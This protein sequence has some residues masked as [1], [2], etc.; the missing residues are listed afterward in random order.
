LPG[1]VSSQI[2][3][4]YDDILQVE[5]TLFR[6]PRFVFQDS[7]VFQDM[8]SVPQGEGTSI[9]GSDD[10]H[11][12]VLSSYLAHDFEQLMKVLLPQCVHGSLQPWSR[13]DQT[14]DRI[15]PRSLTCRRRTGCLSSSLRLSGISN[16]FD[17]PR[18]RSWTDTAQQIRFSVLLLLRSTTS[19]AGL[20]RPST[21][22]RNAKSL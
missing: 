21:N 20:S 15:L 1:A 16:T 3:D 9:E 2:S 18:L 13:A 12:L 22:L 8:L 5:N 10:A 6:V 11:P 4:G 19:L 7:E 14:A 17:R